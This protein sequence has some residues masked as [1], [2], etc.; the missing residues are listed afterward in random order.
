MIIRFLKKTGSKSNTSCIRQFY[1]VLKTRFKPLRV[2]I[3]ILLII[4]VYKYFN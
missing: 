1:N 3:P 2:I 4:F